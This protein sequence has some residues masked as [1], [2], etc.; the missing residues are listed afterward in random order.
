MTKHLT[1]TTAGSWSFGNQ[2]TC[3]WLNSDNLSHWNMKWRNKTIRSVWLYLPAKPESIHGWVIGVCMG[4]A[5]VQSTYLAPAMMRAGMARLGVRDMH[6]LMHS[7]S[8][9]F[10]TKALQQA[11]LMRTTRAIQSMS[12]TH[13]VNMFICSSSPYTRRSHTY[14]V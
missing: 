13:S 5:Y 7:L 3:L 1:M 2:S 6:M 12:W 4:C 14:Q 11:Y 10:L 9:S 8:S